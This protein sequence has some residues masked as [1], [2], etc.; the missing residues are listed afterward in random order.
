MK[1]GAIMNQPKEKI[2]IVEDERLVAKDIESFLVSRGYDVPTVVSSGEEAIR[3]AREIKP[4]L[5]LMDVKLKGALDG[6]EASRL[7][8]KD[9]AHVLDGNPI[10]TMV[11]DREH[12]L[13]L[14]N[15]ACEVLTGVPRVRV[16]GKPIDST[17]FYPDQQRPVPADLVLEMDT[18]VIESLYGHRGAVPSPDI[19][20]AYTAADWLP[21]KGLPRFLRFLADRLHDA[22]GQ[23][24][25]VIETL[26]DRTEQRRTEEKLLWESAV[27]RAQAG[28]SGELIRTVF[29]IEDIAQRTLDEARELTGSR[30]GFVSVIDPLSGD[31]ISYT[32]TPMMDRECLITG[33]NRRV[34]FS[35]GADGQYPGLWG[36]VLNKRKGFYTNVPDAH[37]TSKCAIYSTP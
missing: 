21:I 35:Q 11:I 9:L 10:A 1:I 33:P 18:E 19:P 25:G 12:R 6:I 17:L 24:I 7:I 14:W 20:E 22:Q 30:H 8:R 37:P 34:R 28:L 16:L 27:N 32:L 29:S 3:A 36:E 4:D 26:Q 15:R 2:L 31:N 23:V 5:V 13:V